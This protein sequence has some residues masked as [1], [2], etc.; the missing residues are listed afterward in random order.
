M[1]SKALMCVSG[2]ISLATIAI[3]AQLAAQHTHYKLVDMGTLGGQLRI[4]VLEFLRSMLSC[5]TTAK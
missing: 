3:P 4:L 5:G 1:K 2:M